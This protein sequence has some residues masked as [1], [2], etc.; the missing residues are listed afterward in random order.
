[1]DAARLR[2]AVLNASRAEH[3]ERMQHDD[4]AA[5]VLQ[6]YRRRAVEPLR[7]RPVSGCLTGRGEPVRSLRCAYFR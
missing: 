6:C 1:V 3:L 4:P 2:Q 5:Q 7:R